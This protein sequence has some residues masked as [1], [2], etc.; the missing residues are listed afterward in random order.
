[1]FAWSCKVRLTANRRKNK[2]LQRDENATMF[3]GARVAPN[4]EHRECASGERVQSSGIQM[5]IDDVS[6]SM[7]DW[8]KRA[9][10]GVDIAFV[11]H[12]EPVD[13]KVQARTA[14]ARSCVEICFRS[15]TY[16]KPDRAL[17]NRGDT[18]SLTYLLRVTGVDALA[19]QRIY[20][21]IYFAAHEGGV[22]K[23]GERPSRLE[24]GLAPDVDDEQ[25]ILS[26]TARLFRPAEAPPA[27]IVTY[28]LNLQIRPLGRI[29]GKV[30]TA[31]GTP[32]MRA[33]IDARALNKRV[34]SDAAGHFTIL[35]APAAGTVSLTV[36]A[37]NR[38]VDVLVDTEKQAEIVIVIPKESEHA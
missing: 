2:E 17:L 12:F 19:N 29:A 32:I 23:I 21:E 11:S 30:V 37:R 3:M 9:V 38:S 28:P 22:F 7:E 24:K 1:M 25:A 18:F 10:S 27:G 8:L 15:I 14:G 5:H 36:R 34:V 4:H 35:G 13:G 20:S 31:D 26:L 16:E 33:E 6:R